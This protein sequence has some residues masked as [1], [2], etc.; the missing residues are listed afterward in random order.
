MKNN[1]RCPLG[2]NEKVFRV[3]D[4]KVAINFAIVAELDCNE[5]EEAWRQAMDSAQLR[6]PNLSV[7]IIGSHY[8]NLALNL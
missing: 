4:Q 3:L 6:H 5:P 2:I 7:E 1:N 8:S